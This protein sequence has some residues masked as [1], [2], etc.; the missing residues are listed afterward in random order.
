MS[1]L[2]FVDINEANSRRSAAHHHSLR[3][4]A[5]Y[6][7]AATS[8]IRGRGAQAREL[9]TQGKEEQQAMKQDNFE[10]AVELFKIQ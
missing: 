4:N 8:Y 6:R 10:A 2:L 7:A 5:F 9:A 3:R 1:R